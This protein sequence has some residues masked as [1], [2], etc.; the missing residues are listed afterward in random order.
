MRSTREKILQ[1]LLQ[2]PRSTVNEL[3][4]TVGINNISVR[5]HLSS[6]LADDLIELEEERHGVGRPRQLYSLSSSGIEHFPTRY[7]DFTNRLLGQLKESLPR[8]VFDRMLQQMA[9]DWS[10]QAAQKAK[11]M[12]ME[13]KLDYLKGFLLEEG[14][15]IDWEKCG[16]QYMIHEVACPY[17]HI[18]QRHPEICQM[19]H[20]LISALLSMPVVKT[21]CVAD[22]DVRCSY[23]IQ[24]EYTNTVE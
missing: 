10:Q 8:P 5:H 18:S 24:A 19:D 15:A 6:L 14:F 7:L 4:L 21:S 22:G 16:N 12:S 1:T 2:R 3:A 20:A 23:V 17:F 13:Q 11:S 9:E